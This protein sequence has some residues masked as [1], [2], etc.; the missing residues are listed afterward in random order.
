MLPVLA[1]SGAWDGTWPNYASM[2]VLEVLT[3]SDEAP[4]KLEAHP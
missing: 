3:V 4:L 1:M 2:L